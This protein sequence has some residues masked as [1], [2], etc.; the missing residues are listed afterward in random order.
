MTRKTVRVLAAIVVGLVLALLVLE[1]TDDDDAVTDV[2]PLL[3][4]FKSRANDVMR[5]VISWPVDEEEITIRRAGDSWVVAARDDYPADVGKL[6]QLMIALA[7]ARIVEEKTSDPEQYEKLGVDDPADGGDG[8]RILADGAGFSYEVILGDAAR[9]DFRYARIPDQSTSYLIDRNPDVP[10]SVGDWLLPE[11]IDI[12]S[13]RVRRVSISHADGDNIVIEKSAEDLTDFAV[14]G[15][16]A[17]RELSYATVGNGVAGALSNLELEDVRA[18]DATTTDTRVV[19][20][21]WDGL[22]ITA[23][24]SVAD[25]TTWVA[26]AV[27]AVPVEPA[28]DAA[29]GGENQ[30]SSRPSA[31]SQA[32]E[33]NARLSGWQYQLPDYKKNLLIRRWDD[34]LK[35]ADDS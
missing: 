15:I 33:L 7:D 12:S 4:E 29:D 14:L 3:P 13:E 1:R 23:D 21:T 30:D 5:V 35:D 9:R 24:V 25:D 10:E 34:I 6:R 32:E 26:F 8:P 20:E 16:P 2:R 18:R 17:G 19:Y 22:E 28:A 11:V 31:A 27:V